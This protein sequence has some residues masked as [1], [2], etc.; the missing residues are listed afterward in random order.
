MKQATR[1]EREL[2]HWKQWQSKADE[3]WGWQSPAG[4]LRAARRAELFRNLGHMGQ[5]ST[6]LEIGC[7]TGE[8]TW[9]IARHV[10][11][12]RATDLSPELLHRA[13]RRVRT[14]CSEAKVLFEAQDAM[15]L[16]LQND[17]FDTAFGCSIL[18][19]VNA[20]Q[21]LREV[22]RVL[23]PGGWCVFSEPNMLN[24]Q[25][26]LQ[27]NVGFIK[28]RMGDSP[29]ETAFFRWEIRRLL[30]QAGFGQISVRPFDFL[31][32]LTPPGWLKTVERLGVLL[33]NCPGLRQISGPLI[34]CAQKGPQDHRTTR[35]QDSSPGQ[36]SGSPV[37]VVGVVQILQCQDL[38]CNQLI[39]K[40]RQINY[41]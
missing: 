27:K 11:E 32:P 35:P 8:F 4:Q 28:R 7:G 2:A 38:W 16:K 6:V 18:H 22:Y 36:R 12:L 40:G 30:R 24:P 13:E 33:E 21:A 19:H 25:I 20:A 10:H 14:E 5:H 1:Q 37:V 34:R 39:G 17:Q 9:R 29:D 41:N 3:V 23:K 15:E 26:A 31:H